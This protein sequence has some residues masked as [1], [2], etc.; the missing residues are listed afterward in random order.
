MRPTTSPSASTSKSSSFHWP[1]GRLSAARFRSRDCPAGATAIYLCPS[2][3]P[4]RASL[5]GHSGSSSS[6]NPATAPTDRASRGACSRCP[7][8]RACRR[9]EHN[10]RRR[11][12]QC[13]L[14][15]MP[16]PALLSNTEAS[17]ALRTSSGSRRMS[18]RPDQSCPFRVNSRTPAG[19]R[20]TI[21]RKPS[22]LISWIQFGP[23]GG[24]SAGEGTLT[25]AYDGFLTAQLDAV[26][27]HERGRSWRQVS[28]IQGLIGLG[29]LNSTKRSKRQMQFRLLF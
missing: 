22:S 29:P 14:N 24:R 17:L 19:S 28:R 6:A 3:L 12:S 11:S 4:P 18:C 1:D 10:I 7:R 25:H 26:K 9:A 8:S 16:A 20:R 21:M 23:D 15:R 5:L 27:P 2:L 13:S